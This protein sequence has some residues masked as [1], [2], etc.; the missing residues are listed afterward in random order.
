MRA[1][2]DEEDGESVL[3]Y[4]LNTA[5]TLDRDVNLVCLAK[6][7]TVPAD[8]CLTVQVKPRAVFTTQ[9][10]VLKYRSDAVFR[11]ISDAG[12]K[13]IHGVVT[14]LEFVSGNSEIPVLPK[15]H[16]TRYHQRLW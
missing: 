14:R 4:V 8:T 16:P 11:D 5:V 15:R 10:N 1:Y 7:V 12:D 13:L 3:V 9:R 2:D 6:A